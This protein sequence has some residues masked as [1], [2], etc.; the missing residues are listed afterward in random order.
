VREAEADVMRA[1]QRLMGDDALAVCFLGGLG[2]VFAQRLAWQL[3]G[4]IREPAGTGL[5]GALLLA[6]RLA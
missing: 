1:I 3:Q 5:D 6:R 2:Q 4:L